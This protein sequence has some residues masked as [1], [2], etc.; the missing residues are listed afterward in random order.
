MKAAEVRS[1]KAGNMRKIGETLA[2][3]AGFGI[4]LGLGMEAFGW[5]EIVSSLGYLKT[6]L[7]VL[8]FFAA[9]IMVHILIHELGH[10][11]AGILS[12]YRFSAFRILSWQ[13]VRSGGKFKVKRFHMPGTAGQCLLAPPRPYRPDY[14]YLLYNL[15]GGLANLAASF[16]CLVIYALLPPLPPMGALAMLAFAFAG[17]A[18]AFANLIPRRVQGL[19]NDGWNLMHLGRNPELRESLWQMLDA[20]D[21]LVQ[22]MRYRDF[23]PAWVPEEPAPDADLG[24][25]YV[26][27][28]ALYRLNWLT[29]TRRFGEA[30]A[31]ARRV[32]DVGDRLV[33]IYRMETRCETIS[34]TLL[35]GEDAEADRLAA[36]ERLFTP[37]LSRYLAATPGYP[38]HQRMRYAMARLYHKDEEEARNIL[39]A[40]DRACET[41]PHTGEVEMERELVA[42]VDQIA[43]GIADGLDREQQQSAQGEDGEN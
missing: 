12:G 23:P 13:L 11:G 5:G 42:L 40:F 3:A 17:W 19:G 29:D 10:L 14:P 36:A 41:F 26:C 1:K 18:S 22:G 30:L 24:D 37:E 28:K 32:L 2:L 20:N 15:G 16:V 25:T 39:T 27:A 8:V 33:M 43:D 6:I 31:L 34:L 7:G 4:P 9:A 35:S 21:H 38:N